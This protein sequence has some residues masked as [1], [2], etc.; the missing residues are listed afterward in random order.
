MRDRAIYTIEFQT[1]IE[2]GTIQVPREYR[3]RLQEQLNDSPVRVIIY[4]PGQ[5]PVA[6]Y[7]DRLLTNPLH[8]EDFVPFGRDEVHERG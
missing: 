6:D 4:L 5:Q 3:Q 7:V 2:N 8:V 1:K